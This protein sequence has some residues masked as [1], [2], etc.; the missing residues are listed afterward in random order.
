MSSLTN[1]LSG[2]PI[3]SYFLVGDIFLVT[4]ELLALTSVC[5]FSLASISS[6]PGVPERLV[7]QTMTQESAPPVEKKSP[8]GLKVQAVVGPS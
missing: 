2:D 5:T 4:W 7:D 1:L 8:W 3:F 6:S